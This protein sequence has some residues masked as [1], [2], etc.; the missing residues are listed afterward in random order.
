M[1]V[2]KMSEKELKKLCKERKIKKTVRGKSISKA[3]KGQLVETL[4]TADEEE[5]DE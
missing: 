3:N 4:E 5:E 1:R 2:D